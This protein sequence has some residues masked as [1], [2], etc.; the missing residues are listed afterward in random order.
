[1]LT[2]IL[3]QPRQVIGLGGNYDEI[4]AG[5]QR[6][7]HLGRVFKECTR[8]LWDRKSGFAEHS[9]AGEKLFSVVEDLFGLDVFS[10][11][12]CILHK[13]S[14][15]FLIGDRY[16]P[17]LLD[18]FELFS[19]PR[20]LVV[21]RDPKSSTYSSLRRGFSENLRQ[22]AVICEEQLTY[23]NAQLRALRPHT[24]LIIN[25]EAFCKQPLEI[26][27]EVARFCGLDQEALKQATL[28]EGVTPVQI[29][30]WRK[31]LSAEDVA[32]LDG[33]FSQ[34][35]QAQWSLLSGMGA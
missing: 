33:F 34:Q 9:L 21:Y 31:S 14:A 4:P 7:R 5:S 10:D 17:D 35:R 25:Y 12:T 20:I 32:F 23:L 11:A 22:S 8:H 1:M 15:P 24:Y 19:D 13:R 3:S 16:R 27:A 28:E 6:A 30:R 26:V 29:D 2:R 18:L